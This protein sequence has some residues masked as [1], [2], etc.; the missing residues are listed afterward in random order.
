MR[1]YSALVL[2]IGLALS[3]ACAT[4]AQADDAVA[5]A[6]TASDA[7]RREF[8]FFRQR[9]AEAHA[10]AR[11]NNFG[12]AD[13]AFARLLRD[14]L[15]ESLPE[16]DQRNALST[17]GWMATNL[18]QHARARD[19]YVRATTYAEPDPDVWYR[20]SFAEYD[21]GHYE[22][23]ATV[24]TEI[25][26]RWPEL[27]PN[28]EEFHIHR[29][30]DS[31]PSD[32]AA[33]LALL[34][35]LFDANWSSK[36]GGDSTIWYDLA[37]ARA[38]RGEMDAARAAIRRIDAPLDLV[39]LRS[40]KRFDAVIDASSIAFDP[41]NAARRQVEELQQQA[42]LAPDNLE[43]RTRLS[44]AL[45][46]AGMH[47]EVIAL[48][49]QVLA[50]IANAP[51]NEPAFT[52]I[53]DQV[54]LMNNRAIALRRMGRSDEALTELV[55]ASKLTEDG[56]QSNVNQA[57]NLGMFYCS[58][59]RPDDA[60]QAIAPAESMSG[61]GLMVKTL[62]QYC[63]ALHKGRTRE[64]RRAFAY[65]RDHRTQAPLIYLDALLRDE[66]LD[67]A[68]EYVIDRLA[69]RDRRGSTLQWLQSYSRPEALP[70][71]VQQRASRARL[72]S[73]PDVLDAVAKVGRIARYEVYEDNSMD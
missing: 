26:E 49:D 6:A 36:S 22:A 40:D 29:L 5:I 55:R 19:L 50:A 61:Y 16:A 38:D 73:R 21:L 41:V 56:G 20:L 59:G 43:L 48:A 17:A 7:T 62:V 15:F 8:Q 44:Y 1:R 67:E 60:L 14:P 72:L 53:D 35:A 65:L 27:L 18:K 10:I 63:A 33:Q 24:F 51:A 23:S 46:T 68:A 45:L 25:V 37:V 34:Q 71:D 9:V 39:S 66:R 52:D 69:S 11:N 42:D 3:G 32:S 70:G 47:E 57:L 13:K 28:V 58:L 2:A 12:S 31:L 64:A 54:W 30:R 4:D